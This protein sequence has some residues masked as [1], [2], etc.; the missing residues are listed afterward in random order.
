MET[1]LVATIPT[2]EFVLEET[3]ERVPDIECEFL[4]SAI[5]SSA[6]TMPFLWASTSQPDEL[7]A[8][9]RGDSSLERVRRLSTDGGRALYSI[10]W[11]APAAS[12]IDGFAETD[13]LVLDVRGAS[14]QWKLQILFP[15]RATAS[16]AFQT[17]CDNGMSPSLSRIGNL[18]RRE[19]SK[20]G[21]SA[22]QHSTITQAF[23]TDYYNV[24]RG[25]TLQE[26]ATGFDVSHQA[27]SERLRR[28]H[29]HLVEQTLTESTVGA[30]GR[31]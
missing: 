17:W 11:T 31:L 28:A 18:S 22:T 24:P 1:V 19:G 3:I 8:A 21:L 4:Q 27:V 6:C 10:D 5:H 14:D 20:G 7:D 13:G 26:L 2:G 16:A 9:L 15:D 25:T 23:E 29:S 12:L 30:E